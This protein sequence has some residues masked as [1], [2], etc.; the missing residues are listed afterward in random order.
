MT[1]TEVNERSWWLTLNRKKCIQRKSPRKRD[2]TETRSLKPEVLKD[3]IKIAEK[4][5]KVFTMFAKAILFSIELV[6]R[7]QILYLQQSTSNSPEVDLRWGNSFRG[8]IEGSLEHPQMSSMSI[9]DLLCF[10]F[11][12]ESSVQVIPIDIDL[13]M[14]PSREF[15][16]DR[17]S[18]PVAWIPDRR[19]LSCSRKRS[20]CCHAR[21]SIS[22]R[23][24]KSKWQSRGS[25]DLWI[26]RRR[27]VLAT[28]RSN[29]ED[30]N[31][32][33]KLVLGSCPVLI[34][35]P[36]G[37]WVFAPSFSLPLPD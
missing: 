11:D 21:R 33:Y 18:L 36:R 17:I 6:N 26:D 16:G 31:G 19:T 35:C 10:I 23:H 29:E 30:R 9:K 25:R 15:S 20:A 2:E 5:R 32:T 22:L 7:T 13:S 4:Y 34:A 27:W 14:D 37:G 28:S 12:S 8:M 1:F 3:S 24:G